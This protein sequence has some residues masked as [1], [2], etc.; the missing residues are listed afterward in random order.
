[1][2]EKKKNFLQQKREREKIQRLISEG[3]R[4]NL[5]TPFQNEF[6][7]GLPQKFHMAGSGESP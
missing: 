3:T 4:L 1:M 2:T 5:K 7:S 6:V